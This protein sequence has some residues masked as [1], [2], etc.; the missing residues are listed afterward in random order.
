[1]LDSAQSDDIFSCEV[2]DVGRH[3]KQRL[4]TATCE[5]IWVSVPISSKCADIKRYLH[6]YYSA[7]IAHF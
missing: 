3:L 2:I 5:G 7:F 1:M 6:A 4:T